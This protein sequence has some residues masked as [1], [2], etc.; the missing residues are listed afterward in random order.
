MLLLESGQPADA[1][2]HLETAVAKSPTEANRAALATAYVKNNQ[3][4]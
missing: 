3:N 2:P 4:R 1:I